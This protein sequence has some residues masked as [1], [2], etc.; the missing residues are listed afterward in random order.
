MLLG[1][2]L[3][4]ICGVKVGKG[5]KPAMHA[6]SIVAVVGEPSVAWKKLTSSALLWWR[7][8]AFA[9]Y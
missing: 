1:G 3:R 4:I 9:E 7:I 5:R 6:W 8:I 2:L